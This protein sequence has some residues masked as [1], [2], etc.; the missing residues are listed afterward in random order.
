VIRFLAASLLATPLVAQEYIVTQ[1]P[2]SD[3]DF[4]HLVA[5]AAAPGADCVDEIVT[6]D[7][8][9]VRVT[10][11]PI[12]I[13]YPTEK[14]RELHRALD[15]SIRQINSAAPG[16]NV[17][18]VSKS[19][20]ADIMLFLQTIRTGDAIYSTGL[21]DMDGVPIGAAQVQI[22]WDDNLHLTEAAI[23]FASDIPVPQLGPIMLEELTQAM[24]LMTDIRNPYYETRSVFSE[25]SNTVQKL[26]VQDRMALRRHYPAR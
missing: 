14:A 16:L 19:A 12:P 21:S 1:G 20:P 7:Q 24:G 18:R 2:L 26:G 11:A 17:Q 3:R 23:V 6:W 22:F 15:T 4:Y 10:F 9:V 25:D 5:C 8:P 13:A